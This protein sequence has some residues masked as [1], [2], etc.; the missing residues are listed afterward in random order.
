MQGADGK[1]KAREGLL[2][3]EHSK[4]GRRFLT[5]L[6]PDTRRVTLLEP[7]E[8]DLLM[9]CDGTRSIEQVAELHAPEEGSPELEIGDVVRCI[10]FFEKQGLVDVIGLR[11]SDAPPP[12]PETMANLQAAYREWHKEPAKTGQMISP[13]ERVPPFPR[14]DARVSP[15]LS[16]TVAL[17]EDGENPERPRGA[18]TPG[19]TLVLAGSESVLTHR[20]DSDVEAA[21]PVDAGEMLNL[22]A[23]VDDAVREAG[24]LERREK[25]RTPAPREMTETI[26]VV[27]GRP[28]AAKDIDRPAT[29]VSIALEVL[30]P[31]TVGVPA[32]APARAAA[33]SDE[34]TDE[35]VR[36]KKPPKKAS[37]KDGGGRVPKAGFDEGEDTALG[38]MLP[39]K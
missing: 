9:L 21:A 22:L 24:E 38:E 8:H 11:R 12:G 4:R 19:S 6:D 31:T 34:K 39:E 5:L 27:E 13:T 18:V 1:P 2:A 36:E 29:N 20:E 26:Q 7:W 37:P 35:Y 10:K 3:T 32:P 30:N 28:P 17:P 33:E 16:P 25:L 23:A 14:T 15:G